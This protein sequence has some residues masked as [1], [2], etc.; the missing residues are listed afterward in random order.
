M[1]HSLYKKQLII[2][3]Y[4]VF[5]S[6]KTYKTGS[7]KLHSNLHIHL[8]ENSRLLASEDINKYI[9]PG[10]IDN[11]SNRG[12]GT[13]VTRKPAYAFLY[14]LNANNITIDG[15]GIIDGNCDKFVNRINPY[16]KNG[17]FYPRQTLVYI[18]NCKNLIIKET[19]FTNAPFWSIHFGGCKEVLIEKITIDNPLD[20]ANSDGIDPDHS[21]NVVIKD[22]NI[23]CADD[24][25]CLKNCQ[26]NS[27]YPSTKKCN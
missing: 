26:G 13:P 3:D 23:S 19:K 10:E 22:C 20:V 21:Q 17:T 4:I 7:L 12:V 15:K 18:E 9:K 1:I 16:Y 2:N 11:D 24:C 8:Q 6:G 27:E 5:E 14:S 25:I